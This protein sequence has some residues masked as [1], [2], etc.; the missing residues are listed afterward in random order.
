MV[1]LWI[2]SSVATLEAYE[3]EGGM[4]SNCS[5][6]KKNTKKSDF[7]VIFDGARGRHHPTYKHIYS[8]AAQN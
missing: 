5:K 2:Y 8:L 4:K 7:G 3:S 1:K 6:N